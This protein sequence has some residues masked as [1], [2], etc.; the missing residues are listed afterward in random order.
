MRLILICF[1]LIGCAPIGKVQLASLSVDPEIQPYVTIYE[2]ESTRMGHPIVVRN[3]EARFGPT[4][5]RGPTVIGYCQ[6]SSWS[7]T[8]LVVI[9]REFWNSASSNE[10]EHLMFHELGHCLLDL[11]HDDAVILIGID[12]VP[13]SIMNPYIFEESVY[14]AHR[15]YYLQNLF[16]SVTSSSKRS[17]GCLFHF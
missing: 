4:D 7:Y 1:T 2:N 15:E 8:P 9:N 3:L 17:D 16:N 10:R 14:V 11:D 6:R 13:R 12:W 5:F